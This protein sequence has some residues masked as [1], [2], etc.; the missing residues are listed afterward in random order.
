MSTF[1]PPVPAQRKVKLVTSLKT[2]LSEQTAKLQS[3]HELEHDL[4]E[5]VR[6]YAKQR[7]G[8][9]KEYAQSILKITSQMVSK[10]VPCKIQASDDTEKEQLRSPY[11]LWRKILEETET[12]ANSRMKIS[13][14]LL[15][16]VVD[17]IKNFKVERL[18]TLKKCTT[19][20]ENLQEEIVVSTGDLVKA[21]KT[22]SELQK[23]TIQA[24]QHASD[25]QEKLQS[26][27][28]EHIFFKGQTGEECFK[29][30]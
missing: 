18:S 4:L 6:N 29:I 26:G 12:M 22:Y 23:L 16:D 5:D 10:I 20:T 28:V 24:H 1:T 13:Q 15:S 19:L 7:A 21:Q 14:T 17:S 8:I 27:N 2:T 3:K 11:G 25:A 30:K 9:E